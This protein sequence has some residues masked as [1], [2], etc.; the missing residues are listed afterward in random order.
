MCAVTH[1]TLHGK[2]HAIKHGVYIRALVLPTL[3]RNVKGS[4]NQFP[5]QIVNQIAKADV[6]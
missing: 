4:Q 2:G 1:I 6:A 5:P 3:S